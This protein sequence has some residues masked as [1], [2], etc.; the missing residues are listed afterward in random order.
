MT[1]RIFRIERASQ[2]VFGAAFV[3]AFAPDLVDLRVTSEWPDFGA[4]VLIVS[5]VTLSATTR[6]PKHHQY[7]PKEF[8]NYPHQ[9]PT[10]PS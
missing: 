9:N 8:T 7:P 2:N 4:F 3:A 6:N 10:S 1:P 5:P